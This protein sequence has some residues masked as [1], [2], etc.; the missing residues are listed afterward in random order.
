MQ[1]I[2]SACNKPYEGH[3]H[4]RNYSLSDVQIN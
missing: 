4:R 1:A 3:V 2:I